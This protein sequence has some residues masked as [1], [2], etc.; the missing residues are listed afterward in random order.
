MTPAKVLQVILEFYAHLFCRFQ[1]RVGAS[2]ELGQSRTAQFWGA[3][4][5]NASSANLPMANRA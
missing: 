4:Q 5:V 1:V 3:Q 2:D